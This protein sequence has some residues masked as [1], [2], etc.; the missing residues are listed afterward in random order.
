MTL[1]PNLPITIAQ[2]IPVFFV[3]VI[4]DAVRPREDVGRPRRWA[5]TVAIFYR[6][7]AYTIV[8]ILGFSLVLVARG[9]PVTG[10]FA[11]TDVVL[12]Y[13]GGI[14]LMIPVGSRIDD[15]ATLAK[16]APERPSVF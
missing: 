14:L 4:I 12:L 11:G 6:I 8:V 7:A 10:F 9:E 5:K 13:L 15:L 1:D 3:I 16:R 2:I